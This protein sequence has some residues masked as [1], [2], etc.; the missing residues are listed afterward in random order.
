VLANVLVVVELQHADTWPTF[1]GVAKRKFGDPGALLGRPGQLLWPKWGV[2]V[3]WIAQGS[4]ADSVN[5]A[6]A[7]FY[8]LPAPTGGATRCE[9]GTNIEVVCQIE[10][11]SGD[12]IVLSEADGVQVQVLAMRVCRNRMMDKFS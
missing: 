12:A 9:E 11:P 10:V 1:E 5:D 3:E 4:E 6:N 2:F 7:G 8:R